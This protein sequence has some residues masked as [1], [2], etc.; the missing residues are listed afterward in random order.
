LPLNRL[1]ASVQMRNTK[2]Q[3]LFAKLFP[4]KEYAIGSAVAHDFVRD[5]IG[6]FD[7]VK[8]LTTSEVNDVRL[9]ILDELGDPKADD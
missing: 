3:E 7:G 8:A 9:A 4:E 1:V 2:T 6:H 5:K